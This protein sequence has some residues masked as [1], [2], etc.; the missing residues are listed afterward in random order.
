LGDLDVQLCGDDDTGK[1]LQHLLR[2]VHRVAARNLKK[3]GY[4][5]AYWGVH[6]IIWGLL[7]GGAAHQ[8][9]SDRA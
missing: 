4:V 1:L 2:D 9:R 7:G 5:N 3:A 8:V 6:D